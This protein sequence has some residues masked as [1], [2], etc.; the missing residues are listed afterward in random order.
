MNMCVIL[1]VGHEP[2]YD[3]ELEA[4]EREE[5]GLDAAQAP[6]MSELFEAELLALTGFIMKVHMCTPSRPHPL[7][8][9]LK[10]FKVGV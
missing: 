3:P 4:E 7:P 9:V 10:L 8:Y 1:H 5:A 6:T 2:L